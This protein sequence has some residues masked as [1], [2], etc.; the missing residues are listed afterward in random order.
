MKGRYVG[1]WKR[2]SRN[3]LNICEIRV[4]GPSGESSGNNQ[5]NN[6]HNSNN[7]N[8]GISGAVTQTGGEQDV[9]ELTCFQFVEAVRENKKE[10]KGKK[11]S[12]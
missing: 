3:Y 11:K 2:N 10:S 4:F 12:R 6:N 8:G 1:I 5:Q 9:V 7:N